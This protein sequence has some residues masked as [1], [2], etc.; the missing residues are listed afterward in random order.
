MHTERLID[1]LVAD[2]PTR[3]APLGRYFAL[4]MAGGFL[5]SAIMFALLLGPREGA[6]ASLA[7]PRFVLKFIETLLFGATAA[8][9]ALRLMRPAAPTRA[10]SWALLAAPVL[11]AVAVVVELLLVPASDWGRRLVGTNWW[12]CLTF[13]PLLSLPLLA[14]GLLGLRHGAPTR[15]RVAGAVAGL[16]AGGLAA[17]LYASHCID[18]SP[19]FVATWYTIAIGLVALAGSLLGPRVLRW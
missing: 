14:A 6:L 7:E 15:P 4:V 11:L 12:V 13:V 8:A 5:L 9:L 3:A 19:L 10:V 16:L 2:G 18:D 17:A 1:A